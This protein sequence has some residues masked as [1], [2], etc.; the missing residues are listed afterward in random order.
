MAP[1]NDRSDSGAATQLSAQRPSQIR[2]RRARCPDYKTL[3]VLSDR[4]TPKSQRPLLRSR[5]ASHMEVGILVR[6]VLDGSARLGPR[7]WC[8]C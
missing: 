2:S 3:G 7:S 1:A 4:I 6:L 5:P 8:Q